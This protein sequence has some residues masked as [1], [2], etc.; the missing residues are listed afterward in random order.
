M[1]FPIFRARH[2]SRDIET[3]FGT[4]VPLASIV[5]LA[6]EVGIGNVH[7]FGV[8]SQDGTIFL[9]KIQE[10]EIVLTGLNHIVVGLIPPRES[11]EFGPG[12]MAK[13]MEVEA[14]NAQEKKIC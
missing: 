13:G 14:V 7:L 4:F 2:R 6:Q 8:D 11:G 5:N 12:D 1:Q 10:F 9:V 3:G